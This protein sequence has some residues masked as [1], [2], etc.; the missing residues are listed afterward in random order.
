MVLA[1]F[2]RV[3]ATRRARRGGNG[4]NPTE[5]SGC[6][7]CRSDWRNVPRDSYEGDFAG[8]PVLFLCFGCS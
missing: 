4:L 6:R 2:K 8:D 3:P 1:G 7:L 5:A